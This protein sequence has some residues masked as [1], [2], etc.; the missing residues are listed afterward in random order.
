MQV[1]WENEP[2]NERIVSILINIQVHG[3]LLGLQSQEA[4]KKSIN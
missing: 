1:I 2:I 3:F 4:S